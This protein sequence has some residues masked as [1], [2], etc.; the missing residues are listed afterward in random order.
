[1]INANKG[2]VHIEGTGLEIM[3]DFRCACRSVKKILHKEFGEEVGKELFE[4]LLIEDFEESALKVSKALRNS[5]EK[6]SVEEEPNEEK[7]TG[8]EPTTGN[9]LLDAILTAVF[10][11]GVE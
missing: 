6:E 7:S 8:K 1:M 11:G 10:G 2:N 4:A 5:N 3:A 9:P